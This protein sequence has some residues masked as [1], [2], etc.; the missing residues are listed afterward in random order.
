MRSMK[1][2]I[3][4]LAT[5]GLIVGAAAAPAAS[6]HTW[7][8]RA[9]DVATAEVPTSGSEPAP[10]CAAWA[11]WASYELALHGIFGAQADSYL[12]GRAD[13][14]CGQPLTP[15]SLFHAGDPGAI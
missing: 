15:R 4:R 10:E 6:A 8:E 12:A 14:P 1:N 7:S 5:L 11:R 13:N 9:G 2:P 3:I